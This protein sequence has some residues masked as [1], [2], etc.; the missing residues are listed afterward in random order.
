MISCKKIIAVCL[1]FAIAIS[2]GNAIAGPKT[3]RLPHC[4][5]D[6]KQFFHNCEGVRNYG[7][8]GDYFGEF[9]NNMRHGKGVI[10][11]FYDAENSSLMS[12][13]PKGDEGRAYFGY[14]S[15]EKRNG[16]GIDALSPGGSVMLVDGPENWREIGSG[17]DGQWI[18]DEFISKD[19]N[20]EKLQKQKDEMS[21]WLESIKEERDSA[22]RTEE[23]LAI[24]PPLLS[25]IGFLMFFFYWELQHVPRKSTLTYGDFKLEVPVLSRSIAGIQ[26]SFPL[27]NISK[28]DYLNGRN[29]YFIIISVVFILTSLT[30]SEK[31]FDSSLLRAIYS[32]FLGEISE[33]V[34]HQVNLVIA[35]IFFLLGISSRYSE[36]T[37]QIG[38]DTKITTL[39][40]GFR[41]KNPRKFLRTLAR[42]QAAAGGS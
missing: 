42:R 6:E 40:R 3:E 5:K 17:R 28:I 16:W 26:E 39:T 4:P 14:W 27:G 9:Q 18:N 32:I 31:S 20:S 36:I 12:P 22:Q 37:I 10:G 13:P 24:Y 33:D 35:L 8:Q 30:T 21:R 7:S 19:M 2:F 29:W 15:N 11:G 41:Y 23:L 34:F 1:Q 25:F 38:T